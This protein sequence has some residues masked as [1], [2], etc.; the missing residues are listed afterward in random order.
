MN[1]IQIG[2]VEIGEGRPAAIIAEGCDNHMGSLSRAKEMAQAAKESGADIIKFQLHLPEEEMVKPE[3]EKLT[4]T[5][6]FSKWGSLYGFVEKFLLKPE[7][8]AQLKD[9]CDKI[10]IQYFCTPFSLKAAQL[11]N[12][13]GAEAFKIG[14]GETE[15]LPM[16]EEVAK[17]GKPMMVSTG[18]TSLD[19]LDLTANTLKSHNTPFCL[20]HCISVY[21]I[22]SRSTLKF[23]TIPYYQKRYGV[24]IGWSDHSAPEGIYDEELRR[25]I[26]EAEIL[27][28]ALGSGAT[29]IEKHFTLD[30]NADDGDSFFSH[31]P[32]TLKNLVKNVRHWEEALASRNE[33]LKAEEWVRL[34]AK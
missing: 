20:A 33:I 26:P 5:P 27:A 22:K 16:I 18:M 30:R 11:L 14:S 4:S 31:D 7:E 9:Y 1:T 10:G 21:P 12:E 28:V 34:W 13:M 6:F 2:K 24:P 32:S 25:Q 19:E 29:F 23:G 8:H 17:F 15:D 3:I